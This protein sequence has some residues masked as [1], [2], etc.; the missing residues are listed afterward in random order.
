MCREMRNGRKKAWSR[1]IC[2]VAVFAVLLG[3]WLGALPMQTVHAVGLKSLLVEGRDSYEYAY[4]VLDL[5][6]IERARAQLP[7]FVM[8]RELLDVAMQRAAECTVYYNHYRPDGSSC[9]TA[10]KR[11]QGEIIAI[12]YGTPLE[13]VSAWLSVSDNWENIYRERF[14]SIG[15]GAFY[16]NG[17]YTWALVFGE[18]VI[19]SVD[20]PLDNLDGHTVYASEYVM[21][22]VFPSNQTL[23]A[24]QVQQLRVHA[25]NA[26]YTDKDASIANSSYRWSSSNAAVASVDAEGRVTAHSVGTAVITATNVYNSSDILTSWITVQS[27][28]VDNV[29][30]GI[31]VTPDPVRDP[32]QIAQ[33]ERFVERMYT[34]ALNRP[35]DRH[36]LISWENQLIQYQTD[37][38]GIAKGFF[39]SDEFQSRHL[40]DGDYVDTLYRT[41]FDREADPKGRADWI[42]ALE[43][44]SNRMAV[45]SGF[46]N[47]AEF[48][49]LCDRFGIIRGMLL[50]DGTIILNT[51]VREFVNRLYTKVLGRTGETSGV[52][53]WT[54]QLNMGIVTPEQAAKSFFLS[55]EFQGRGLSNGEY[56]EVLYQTFLDRYP[57]D[58]GRAYWIKALH[59]GT[60]RE[61][62]LEGFARSQEFAA[63]VARYGL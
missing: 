4:Q 36:G 50:E 38:A 3:G 11:L 23:G 15:V 5:L 7:A 18:E 22:Y 2:T 14:H 54:N 52:E 46:V 24:G 51:R 41:L 30:P 48:S 39:F 43:R 19:D 61:T 9:F 59:E 44:G 58:Q 25:V 28:A 13:V 40:S 10:S 63:I 31:A 35:S 56:V 33:I 32:A 60:S 47:S 20:Q 16:N 6:N 29:D 37:A 1:L 26:C 53:D 45:L 55:E 49:S 12:G 21:P 27:S 8:D 34:V 57:D 17:V 62:V 42:S